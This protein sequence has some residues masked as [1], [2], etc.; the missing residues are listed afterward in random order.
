MPEHEPA[1]HNGIQLVRPMPSYAEVRR[2][3]TRLTVRIEEVP[4]GHHV[5]LP[6]PTLRWADPAYA[7]F[8]GPA[9]RTPGV[10]P[11]FGTPDRWWL[12][13][14]GD[15]GLMTYAL[16]RSVPFSTELPAGPVVVPLSGRT[17]LE[18]REDEG[19][20]HEL[21]TAAIPQFFA[22]TALPETLR[23]DLAAALAAVLPSELRPWYRALTPDFFDWLE[24]TPA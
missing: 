19:L 4:I 5:S 12:V 9:V 17:R 16:V 15:L 18:K 7:S 10:S 20:L 21:L 13:R 6:M 2:R 1:G 11:R 24:G 23:A 22:G 3:G 14:A 8:A